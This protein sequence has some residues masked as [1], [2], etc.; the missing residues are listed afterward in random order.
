MNLVRLCGR[1]LLRINELL[2]KRSPKAIRHGRL[3]L[4]WGRLIF[5]LVDKQADHLQLTTTYFFRN[6]PELKLLADISTRHNNLN[7]TVIGCSEGAEV[8]S[9][10]HTLR[11]ARPNIKLNVQA[12][13]ISQAAIDIARQG[14]FPRESRLFKYTTAAELEE[15]FEQIG[16]TLKV[17]AVYREDVSWHHADPTREPTISKLP[18]QDIVFINR[19]LF[20][21]SKAEAERCLRAA[22][23]LVRQDGYLFVSG[24]N[25]DLRSRIAQEQGW[26]QITDY[27]EEIHSGDE[28]M[29]NDWPFRRWGLEPLD[30]RRNDWALRYCSVF[31]IASRSE[32]SS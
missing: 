16:E 19:L 3:G 13:D 21:M 23:S 17:K 14:V 27:L 29:T 24:V 7:L 4:L 6:R 12:F 9:I 26:R 5:F 28:T 8:L 30:K 11:K 10:V 32:S 15:L 18:K 2:W 22:A 1:V 20:H 31:Q 25:L